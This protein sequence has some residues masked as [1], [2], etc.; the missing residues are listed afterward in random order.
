MVQSSALDDNDDVHGVDRDGC[1]SQQV[2]LIVGRFFL[3]KSQ[4]IVRRPQECAR[5]LGTRHGK[6]GTRNLNW[7][8]PKLILGFLQDSG[9]ATRR[10]QTFNVVKC[11]KLISLNWKISLP[12]FTAAGAR[13]DHETL[14]KSGW[15]SSRSGFC[16][17]PERWEEKWERKHRAEFL[18]HRKINAVDAKTMRVSGLIK[19]LC[20]R[21]AWLRP[22]VRLNTH[23]SHTRKFCISFSMMS[24]NVFH[25]LHNV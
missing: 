23:F 22:Q 15:N 18:N 6:T 19:K 8:Q 3:G 25:A 20:V 1:V 5:F 14:R 11:L 9:R 12:R 10:A 21:L 13:R 2:S 24:L 17:A 4:H 16:G 7:L